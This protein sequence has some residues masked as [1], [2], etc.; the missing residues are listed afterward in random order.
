MQRGI[1]KLLTSPEV[2]GSSWSSQPID[3][4]TMKDY[5]IHVVFTGAAANI[6]IQVSNDF[7]YNNIDEVVNWTTISGSVQAVT[8]SGNGMFEVENSGHHWVRVVVSGSIV[9]NSANL[10]SKSH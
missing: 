5:G 2:I 3:V 8:G 4:S 9:L 6:Y 10:V 7:V 1:I